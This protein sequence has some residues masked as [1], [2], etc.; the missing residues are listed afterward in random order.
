M[1][2]IMG[3][4][5]YDSLSEEEKKAFVELCKEDPAVF[6]ERVVGINLKEYQKVYIRETFKKLLK[7][8]NDILRLQF[9]Q[10]PVEPRCIHC[11]GVGFVPIGP[12][13]RGIKKCPYC[14]WEE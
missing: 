14:G 6:I 2:E 8:K 10:E 12:R 3:K 11:N 5:A 1:E 9:Q 7:E 13:V 4:F